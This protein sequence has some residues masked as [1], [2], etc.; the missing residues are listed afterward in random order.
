ML[1]VNWPFLETQHL[2]SCQYSTHVWGL[3]LGDLVNCQMLRC[4]L[5]AERTVSRRNWLLH[6]VPGA[7]KWKEDLSRK[8]AEA[9]LRQ[10]QAA[11]NLRKLIYGTGKELWLRA[12]KVGVLDCFV[13][14]R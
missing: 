13:Q 14:N 2:K 12:G 10:Q 4:E 6:C 7:L 8:A 3:L 9:F 11:P 5:A 1:K